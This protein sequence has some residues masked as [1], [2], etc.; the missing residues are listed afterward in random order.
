[1]SSVADDADDFRLCQMVREVAAL[2]AVRHPDLLH[3]A[4]TILN[5]VLPCKAGPGFASVR[6][7]GKRYTFS[8]GQA[9]VVEAL[10]RA[11][12]DGTLDVRQEYLVELSGA[13]GD[14]PRLVDVFKDNKAWKKLIIT[15]ECRGT[16]RLNDNPDHFSADPDSGDE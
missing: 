3:H 7:Y 12:E 1:M 5:R 8:G 6:W 9:R 13:S 2:I 11:W 4:T 10:W 15:G 14:N 16:Y